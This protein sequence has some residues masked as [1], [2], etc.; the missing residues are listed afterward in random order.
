MTTHP[1][2]G[3]AKDTLLGTYRQVSGAAPRPSTGER[4]LALEASIAILKRLM[5][6]GAMLVAGAFLAVAQNSL[7]TEGQAPLTSG[8]AGNAAA[9]GPAASMPARTARHHGTR[10][11]RMYMMSVN[12]AHK[13][14]KLRPPAVRSR[15]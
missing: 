4:G 3:G 10:H 9:P 5:M 12:R 2:I 11:H 6:V 7:P 15:R 13:G 14:A 8:A 1:V